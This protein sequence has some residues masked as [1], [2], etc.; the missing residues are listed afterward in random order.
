MSSSI[1]L[2]CKKLCIIRCLTAVS[3][4]VC[5]QFLLLALFLLFVNFDL[6]HPLQWISG[7]IGLMFSVYTWFSILPLIASVILYGILLGSSYL[8]VKHYFASRFRWV[9]GH[10]VRKLLFFGAHVL[11]GFLT[12]WLYV[13]FLRLDFR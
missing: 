7:T 2:E 12:A 10:F 11:V 9:I 6:L 5:S 8:A 3:L 1:I 4:S 13:K